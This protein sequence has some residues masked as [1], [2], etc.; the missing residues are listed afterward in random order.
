MNDEE[1]RDRLDRIER[2]LTDQVAFNSPVLS[3]VQAMAYTNHRARSSFL[4]W[5][6][7]YAPNAACGHGRYTRA[8]LDRGL[9]KESRV[10]RPTRRKQ[11]AKK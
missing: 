2:L 5:V 7:K 6:G 8:A 11:A 3:V 4:D 1:L 9:E 10:M